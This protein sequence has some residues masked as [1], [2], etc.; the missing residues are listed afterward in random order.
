MDAPA[1]CSCR[2]AAATGRAARS[3]LWRWRSRRSPG[4]VAGRKLTLDAAT[5]GNPHARRGLHRRGDYRVDWSRENGPAPANIG[6]APKYVMAGVAR[7]PCASEPPSATAE[8]P[9][10]R[11][12]RRVAGFRPRPFAGNGAG[13]VRLRRR[14]P[15]RQRATSSQSEGGRIASPESG[16]RLTFSRR[17]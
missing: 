13:S 2:D 3:R 17:Q 14:A 11:T 12:R 1:G 4:A 6:K 16:G 5:I 8:K 15:H 9:A 7:P 10:H